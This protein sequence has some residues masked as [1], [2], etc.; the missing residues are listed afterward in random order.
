MDTKEHTELGNALRFEGIEN[1]P[2]LR[3]DEKGTL[4]LRLQRCGD[5]GL[6]E[7]M[8]L[9]MSAGEII[10]MAADFF[11]DRDWNMKLDLPSCHSFNFAEQFSQSSSGSLGEYLIEQ[12]IQEAEENAFIKAYNNLASPDVNR[13]HI[14]LIYKID[15]SNYIPFSTTLN[16]YAKQLMFY[17]IAQACIFQS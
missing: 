13:D 16:D 10:A 4:H 6:P 17:F 2:Y 8:N 9:Q 3:I 1:N 12:P 5:N 14:D 15:N 11:T 7:P